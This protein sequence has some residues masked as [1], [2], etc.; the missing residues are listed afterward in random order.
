MEISHIEGDELAKYIPHR[1]RNLI[2]DVVDKSITP[3]GPQAKIS[4]QIGQPDRRRREI[5]LEKDPAGNECYSPYLFAEFLA[6]GAIVLLTDLPPGTMAYFSTITHFARHRNIPSS[7]P[8]HGETVR[9]KDRGLFKRFTGKVID[10]AGVAAETD[11][12]AFAFNPKTD[13]A[14]QEK[15]LSQKPV[16]QQKKPVPKEKFHWKP[17]GMVFVDELCA[18]DLKAPSATLGYTYP[19]DHPFTEGHFPGNPVMMGIT[20]WIGCADAMSWLA[21]ELTQNKVPAVAGRKSWAAAADVE[22]VKS[23]GAVACEVRGLKMSFHAGAAGA[24]PHPQLQE[25]QRVA[26]HDIVRPMET[27]YYRVTNWQVSN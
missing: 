15:K 9:N 1:G 21:Q 10:A 14:R 5:F 23:D 16:I 3:E 24:M 19:P 22:V 18:L 27:L 11:I 4:L 20:Q 26:F 13:E 12:M 7:G 8:L 2:L 17:A 25:T 6:L